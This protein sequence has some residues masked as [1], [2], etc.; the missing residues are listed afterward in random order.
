MRRDPAIN[1]AE[2]ESRETGQARVVV[3]YPTA[4]SD[5][6]EFGVVAADQWDKYGTVS[7]AEVVHR[8]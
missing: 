7:G 3:K 6:S 4:F 5:G 8:T 2:R 1:R